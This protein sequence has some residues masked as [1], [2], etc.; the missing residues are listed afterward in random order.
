M[1]RTFM[2][3]ICLLIPLS[4]RS[5]R[6]LIFDFARTSYRLSY[7]FHFV[8]APQPVD[9]SVWQLRSDSSSLVRWI[10]PF[11]VRILKKNKTKCNSSTDNGRA[12]HHHVPCAKL[13][14]LPAL[15]IASKNVLGIACIFYFFLNT[16]C[17]FFLL[18]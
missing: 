18:M 8:P 10:V 7:S 16:D 2:S 5:C 17:F 14:P 4:C 15:F 6:P 9:Y 1:T 11:L 12:D 3:Y 13:G